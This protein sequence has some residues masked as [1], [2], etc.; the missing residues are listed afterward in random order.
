MNGVSF[1]V[2]IQLVMM[3]KLNNKHCESATLSIYP[4]LVEIELDNDGD[5]FKDVYFSKVN[6]ITVCL[7]PRTHET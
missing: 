2:I 5:K 1:F 4:K 3:L 7:D 6:K